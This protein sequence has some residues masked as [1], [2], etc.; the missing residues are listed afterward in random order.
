MKYSVLLAALL[1][2]FLSGCASVRDAGVASYHIKTADAEITVH[3]GKEM[4][5]LEASL[6]KTGNDYRF[7]IR[8]EGVKAFR[9]QELAA[10]AATSTAIAGAKAATA[11]LVAPAAA[12]VGAA[13]IGAL[14]Q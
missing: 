1:A 2:I 7:H 3:N 6:E 12:A 10:H 5:F 9:G 11:V 4:D 13:A 14:A 8:Q